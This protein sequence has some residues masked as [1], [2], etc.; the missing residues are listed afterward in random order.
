MTKDHATGYKVGCAPGGG[1][2]GLSMRT[3]E[4]VHGRLWNKTHYIREVH[5][6]K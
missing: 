6:E 3:L 2:G 1:G 4:D 5:E